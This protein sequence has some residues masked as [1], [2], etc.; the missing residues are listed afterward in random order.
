M[1][2]AKLSTHASNQI[3]VIFLNFY[4][5]K[6]MLWSVNKMMFWSINKMVALGRRC[7]WKPSLIVAHEVYD[8]CHIC[9]SQYRETFI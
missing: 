9:P 3:T 6:M 1:V 8:G 2:W 7:Y 5:N 4:I